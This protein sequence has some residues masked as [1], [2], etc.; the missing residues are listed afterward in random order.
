MACGDKYRHLLKNSLGATVDELCRLYCNGPDAESWR[1]SAIDLHSRIKTE[2]Q[3]Y[4][5]AARKA[6]VDVDPDLETEW[7]DYSAE[8]ATLPEVP[9]FSTPETW[10]QLASGAEATMERGACLLEKLDE[11]FRALGEAE[12]KLPGVTPPPSPP[13]AFS[14]IEDAIGTVVVGALVLGAG[15]LAWKI[16]RKG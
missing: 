12:S 15:F 6:D 8:V 16:S 5:T 2:V 9:V 1:Q 11:K 13:G 7:N 3:R 4:V 14:A 10:T